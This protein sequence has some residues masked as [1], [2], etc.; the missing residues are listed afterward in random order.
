MVKHCT[1][2]VWLCVWTSDVSIALA[3]LFVLV[4]CC[5]SGSTSSSSLFANKC[6]LL[7]KSL[8]LRHSFG[9][10]SSYSYSHLLVCVCISRTPL[11]RF[12]ACDAMLYF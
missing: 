7:K 10:L 4:S 3:Y 6:V 11:A 12:R 9:S 8:L 2:S 5:V 1:L